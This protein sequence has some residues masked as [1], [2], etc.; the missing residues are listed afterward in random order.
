MLSYMWAT[1]PHTFENH[2]KYV[3]YLDAHAVNGSLA[4]E[5]YSQLLPPS[6]KVSQSE[7]WA[8]IEENP[9]EVL[10][11]VDGFEGGQGGTQLTKVIQGSS[12]RSCA[13]VAFVRPE[14]R[15]DGFV[16]PDSKLHLLGIKSGSVASC[17]RG[18]A[19]VLAAS[20]LDQD[21]E[22]MHLV[23]AGGDS[24]DGLNS[25]PDHHRGQQKSGSPALRPEIDV[26]ES[27]PL[28]DRMTSPFVLTATIA[29]SQI[30]GRAA[31]EAVTTLTSLCEQLLLALAT[32]YVQSQPLP[33]PEGTPTDPEGVE[34]K[35]EGF[36]EEVTLGVGRLETLAFHTLTSRQ[37]AYTEAELSELIEGYQT[38]ME[39]GALQRSGPSQR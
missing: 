13:V 26:P 3:L 24:A 12:L 36:P 1:A 20:S 9:R 2:Y 10:L 14:A 31:L 8:L 21:S 15:L 28:L 5:V 11:L 34:S 16:R 39:L 4:D 38:L 32:A 18:Y 33:V 30:L 37:L 7:V 29:V 25:S 22:A 19:R 35:Q 6:I 23:S 27:Y 17:L